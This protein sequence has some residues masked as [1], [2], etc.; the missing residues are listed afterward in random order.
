MVIRLFNRHSIFVCLIFLSAVIAV[1]MVVNFNRSQTVPSSAQAVFASAAEKSTDSTAQALAPVASE[2]EMRAVWVPYLS[3]NMSREED[4]SE[5][6]F[7]KK[8]NQIIS[9]AKK[10]GMNTLIVQVRPF[11]DAL[12]PSSYFPWS[13]IVGGTQGVNPGYDPLADMVKASHQ[14]GLKIHAWINPLRIQISNTPSILAVDSVYNTLKNDSQKSGWVVDFKNGKY[15]N[16]AYDGVRRMVADGAKE[17]AQNYE[18]DGI[19]FD[20]YFYPTQDASFDQTAYQDYQESA[21]KSGTPMSLADWR[22]AN[23]SALVSL[24]YQQIKSV[25]PSLVFGIAPQGNI[26]ND[27]AMGADV[28]EWCSVSGYVDYICPQ[29]YV[30]FENPVLPFDTAAETWRQLVTGKDIKLYY[31]LAV[32][33]AGS[34]A[35]SGTW[36]GSNEI[37]ASQVAYGRKTT[38]DGFM[39]YSCDY[40]NTDQTK[41]EVQNVVEVLGRSS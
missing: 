7:L 33:K 3:L 37:L 22:R 15:L 28:R 2:N 19:Q 38:C 26:Q 29:L 6:A 16:P 17:I 14:A 1:T 31:G 40:L 35:D 27:L 20:D 21:A 12:Y 24:V 32:Y 10:C 11:A 25:K 23:I 18:V 39:F 41:Q 13:H 8:F 36:K 5:Q 9:N 30:N 4:K 34:D